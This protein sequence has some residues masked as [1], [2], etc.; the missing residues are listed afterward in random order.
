M[1][2]NNEKKGRFPI[3]RERLNELLG[4]MSIT[5]FAEK[6]GISRQTMG[7]YL[8]GDRIPDSFTLVQ[9]CKACGVSSDWLTGLTGD[10]APK[11]SAVDELCL[12]PKAIRNIKSV[13]NPKHSHHAA[14]KSLN[15]LLESYNFYRI[16]IAISEYENQI[17]HEI[18]INLTDYSEILKF[19]ENPSSGLEYPEPK[20]E[21]LIEGE[22]WEKYP[23]TKGRIVLLHGDDAIDFKRINLE[24]HFG[25]VLNS[26]SRYN[27][28]Q[29]IKQKLGDELEK[30][31]KYF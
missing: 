23:E 29:K 1:E 18:S 15:E 24:R 4:D 28:L 9:I 25:K 2:Q 20:T 12:S 14:I 11:T 27:E 19:L 10:P 7:F 8:N 26:I 3:F 6:V 16:L 17:E 13:C 22:I 30:C 21:M 31:Y 5:E